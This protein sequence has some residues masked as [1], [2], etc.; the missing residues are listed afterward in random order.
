LYYPAFYLTGSGLGLT[1]APQWTVHTLLS[2]GHYETA[3]L[4]LAGLFVIGLAAI[5]I[6]TIRL[7]LDALYPT[8][9][10]VRLVFCAGY[11]VLYEQTGDPFFLVVLGV[12]GAGLA[13]SSIGYVVDRRAS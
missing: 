7:G 1:L 9:M 6:Q 10:G 11:V 2:N 4:R 13:A 12:V 3:A 5:V 8:L